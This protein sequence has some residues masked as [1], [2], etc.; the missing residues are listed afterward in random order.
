MLIIKKLSSV[1]EESF[2]VEFFAL[3]LRKLRTVDDL[4]VRLPLCQGGYF[5]R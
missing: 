3:C 1:A 4:S 2:F 5:L